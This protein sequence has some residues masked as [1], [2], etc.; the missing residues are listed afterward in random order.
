[1][2]FLSI[3]TSMFFLLAVGLTVSCYGIQQNDQVAETDKKH[4]GVISDHAEQL[5]ILLSLKVD[6]NRQLKIDRDLWKRKIRTNTER[7]ETAVNLFVDNGRRR[8]IASRM[9]TS[10]I[11]Q[12][13]SEQFGP[14]RDAADRFALIANNGSYQFENRSTSKTGSLMFNISGD[15][16]NLDLKADIEN[17]TIL[18]N[19]CEHPYRTI[20]IVDLE[21]EFRLTFSS[22]KC[23][24]QLKQPKDGELFVTIIVGDEIFNTTTKHFYEFAAKY[25]KQHRHL[26][27]ILDDVGFSRP[28]SW[29]SPDVAR[30][31]HDQLLALHGDLTSEFEKISLELVDDDFNTRQAAKEKL[32]SESGIYLALIRAKAANKNTPPEQRIA[33]NIVIEE[34]DKRNDEESRTCRYVEDQLLL[35]QPEYLVFMLE[36]SEEATQPLIVSQLEEVTQQKLGSDIEAWKKYVERYNDE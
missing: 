32:L 21:N 35:Y 26:F 6:E 15:K 8:D 13:N 29:Y 25:P 5:R 27:D 2:N 11:R 31:V 28:L 34:F 22:L 4:E 18:I 20:K 36:N 9:A 24:V 12:Q 1:M 30:V 10:R 33:F 17:L 3:P 7:V 19:E 16:V 14:M 23:L